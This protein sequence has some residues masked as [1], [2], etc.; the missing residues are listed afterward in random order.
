[1]VG[2][3]A[4]VM[5]RRLLL[6]VMVLLVLRRGRLLVEHADF[7]LLEVAKEQLLVNVETE[8]EL[9]TRVGFVVVVI[10][11]YHGRAMIRVGS[12]RC[13]GISGSDSDR[14]SS[15]GIVAKRF[16]L[17]ASLGGYRVGRDRRGGRTSAIAAAVFGSALRWLLKIQSTTVGTSV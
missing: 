5:L 13:S 17:F 9:V 10:H 14:S 7:V 15:N 11:D 8:G 12:Y 4:V 6:V 2:A 1:M 16:L 3:A